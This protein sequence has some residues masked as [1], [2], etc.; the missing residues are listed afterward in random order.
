MED[1]LHLQRLRYYGRLV[2]EGP[3]ALWALLVGEQQWFGQLRGDFAWLYANVQSQVFR[4][5]P[6][7][8]AGTQFWTD[9]IRNHDKSW[10]G[11][12]RK[13]FKYATL[14]L[15]IRAEVAVFHQDF[16]QV[17]G[18]HHSSLVPPTPP[19]IHDEAL[20]VCL[21]CGAAF[22]SRNPWAT[23]TFRAHG[24]RAPARFLADTATCDHCFHAFLN[25]YRLYLHLRHSK[26]CFD[27]L[28]NRGVFADALP[29]RGSEAWNQD[30]QQFTLCPYLIAEGPHGN[31]LRYQLCQHLHRMR[32]T[33]SFWKPH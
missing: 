18:E 13:A 24:R 14:Q 21:P 1:E 23:Q 6:C 17:V 10:K 3:D 5:D 12:L 22:P 30:L 28:R 27:S 25:P 29:G 26:A 7:A 31:R 32:P 33:C 15:S 11:L 8:Q 4:P 20:F 19:D 2:R 9:L 16:L